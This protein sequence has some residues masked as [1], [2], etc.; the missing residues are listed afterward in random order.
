MVGASSTRVQQLSALAREYLSF[1]RDEARKHA[2]KQQRQATIERCVDK[3]IRDA[4][5]PTS[6]GT[7]SDVAVYCQRIPDSHNRIGLSGSFHSDKLNRTVSFESLLEEAAL[8]VAERSLRVRSYQEQPCKVSYYRI[9]GERRIYI[10]DLLI[11]L[12]DG[13]ALL[14]EVKPLWQMAV[15]DNRLK[16]KAGQR[17]AQENGWGWV[18]VAYGGRNFSDLLRREIEP[19]AEHALTRA[20]AAGPITWPAMLQLREEAWITA[21]DVAAYAAQHD[22]ALSMTPYQLGP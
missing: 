21:L 12:T 5:W 9:D 20:L 19:T 17:F 1:R 2:R 15:T 11:K 18:T 4:V 3:W 16:S 6:T 7:L 8:G 13:R 22:V 14:I 10:P